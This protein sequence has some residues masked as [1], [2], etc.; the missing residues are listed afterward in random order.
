M[1]RALEADDPKVAL[2]MTK[3]AEALVGKLGQSD[4]T[5]LETQRIWANSLA[6][7]ASRLMT[8][9]QLPEAVEV[10]E[11]SL[12]MMERFAPKL[13]DARRDLVTG[14][15]Q[16]GDIRRQMGDH[17]AAHQHYAKALELAQAMQNEMPRD[18]FALRQVADSNERMGLLLAEKTD[19]RLA[20]QGSCQ[21]ARAWFQKSLNTW[22]TWK[23]M[24][25][26]GDYPLLRK[27]QIVARLPTCD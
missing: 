1:A 18:L 17:G 7:M 13:L 3:R 5:N 9:R 20:V 12:R 15:H 26:A 25:G 8:L 10:A 4:P 16:V 2:I 23:Q 27:N 6:G 14:H 21:E 11:R 22:D 19:P 24:G